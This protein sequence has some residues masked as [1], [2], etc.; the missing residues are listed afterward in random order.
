TKYGDN[1]KISNVANGIADKDA[2]NVSQ[3]KGYI[4]ALGGGAKIEN[5]S[6]TGPKYNLKA[7]DENAKDYTNVGDALTALDNAINKSKE[8]LTKFENK[9]ISFQGN[10]GQ[11]I[12]K[13]LGETLKIQGEGTVTSGTAKD[14]IKVEKNTAGDGLDVK[15]A[16]DIKGL[17]SIE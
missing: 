17:N 4:N 13:K 11:S 9:Q 10:D 3:L 15:L 7:G 6:V 1:I 5:G 16:E 8:N 2:V 14:N 12:S